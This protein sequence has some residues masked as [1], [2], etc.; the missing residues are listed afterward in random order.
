MLRLLRGH[1]FYDYGPFKA[2]TRL[3]YGPFKANTRLETMLKMIMLMI[4]IMM[5]IIFCILYNMVAS[6]HNAGQHYR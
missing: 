6:A 4:M 1:V 5:R 3:D 2:N